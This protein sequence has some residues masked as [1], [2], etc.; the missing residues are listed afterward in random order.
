MKGLK[1]FLIASILLLPWPAFGSDVIVIQGQGPREFRR[2][3]RT[4]EQ[5]RLTG[6]IRVIDA[7]EATTGWTALGNDTTGLDT[8]LDHVLGA[9]SL[10]W[11]K[12]DGAANTIFG[13]IQKTISSVDLSFL[14]E[15]G[16]SFG[17]SLNVSATTDLAYCFLRLGTDVSN[18]NEW[19]VDD[20]SL[21]A[22]WNSLRFNADAPSSAG[23]MGAGWD[24]TVVVYLALG[25]AFD[26]ETSTLAD[27]RVD[28][29]TANVG[30]QVAADINA[31]ASSS[32]SATKVNLVKVGGNDVTTTDADT[33][34][35]VDNLQRVVSMVPGAGGAV[36]PDVGAGN[37][38]TGTR[39][40]V[41]STDDPN[42]SAINADT[43]TIAADTTSID[44]DT[45]TIAADT[46]SIDA[47]T[48]TIAD[49]DATEDSPASADGAQVMYEA[50]TAQKGAV[51]NADAVRPVTN[52]HGETIT[53]G[54]TWATDSNRVEEIDPLDQKYI[55]AVVV[56]V[57]DGT[58]DDGSTCPGVST[59]F[60]YYVSMDGFT[61][62]G[63]QITL[64]CDGGTVTASVE[65]SLQTGAPAT[66][67]YHDV[68]NAFGIAS[69][70][71]TAGAASDLWIDNAGK[72]NTCTYV[73]IRIDATG[74]TNTGDWRV[75]STKTAL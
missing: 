22:D 37:T 41:N 55:P 75:D 38:G 47:D 25:C 40:V 16:G 27:L 50:R 33:G 32:S 57:T 35:G 30:L 15:N 44:A 1:V 17:Y 34:A 52:D 65:C 13:G 10:E 61:N 9:K 6:G 51:D 53:A 14:V 43:T 21:S 7:C 42:L 59:D 39:R 58:D 19:R 24:A 12:V 66:L 68:T 46:T 73:L 74:T 36:Q 20:S 23:A 18:Y 54:Y 63:L 2:V 69:L 4:D 60:C 56:D 64:D 26:L 29:V 31:S 48:T 8:D 67:V 3:V 70:V 28:H 11:D 5:G 49:W 72:L 45:T 71:A 62:S